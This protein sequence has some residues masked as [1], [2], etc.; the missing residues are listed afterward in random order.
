MKNKSTVTKLI[1]I[2][3]DNYQE[4]LSGAV[5][6]REL[7]VSD[8]FKVKRFEIVVEPAYGFDIFQDNHISRVSCMAIFPIDK[9][10]RGIYSEYD[11]KTKDWHLL[12]VRK[13]DINNLGFSDRIGCSLTIESTT[14]GQDS[15][16]TV[17]PYSHDDEKSIKSIEVEAKFPKALVDK[18]IE[19]INSNPY[20]I[21]IKIL[22]PLNHFRS[23]KKDIMVDFLNLDGCGYS[24]T[25][26]SFSLN[27][28][29]VANEY[30]N[31]RNLAVRQN[32][33]RNRKEKFTIILAK[34]F[35]TLKSNIYLI[36][37]IAF[38]VW[39]IVGSF[40]NRQ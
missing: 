11:E 32:D 5:W 39:M 10:L 20:E 36:S 26:I 1:K 6:S 30:Y 7:S 12:E 25:Y 3:N 4:P 29:S 17:S 13:I 24:D 9:A 38:V 15:R 23:D 21:F 27:H 2:D 18:L 16:I 37:W 22:T 34:L 8:I 33:S 31:Y 28:K 14:D 19:A 40:F 35:S